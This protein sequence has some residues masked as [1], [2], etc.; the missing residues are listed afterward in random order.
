M[1]W[2]RIGGEEEEDETNITTSWTIH[3]HIHYSQLQSYIAPPLSVWRILSLAVV[4]AMTGFLLVFLWSA[5]M[6]KVY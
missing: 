5:L 6:V 1:L 3:K 2:V 4:L